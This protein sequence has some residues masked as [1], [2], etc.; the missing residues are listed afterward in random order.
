[1]IVKKDL[2]M[3]AMSYGYIYVAQ[4]A[5]GANPA[6]LIKALKEAEEYN[7]SL[8]STSAVSGNVRTK[9]E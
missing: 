1:M 6:Q 8:S 5:L 2:G 7:S 9:E 3:L 4:V